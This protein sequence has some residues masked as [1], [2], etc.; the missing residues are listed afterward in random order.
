MRAGLATSFVCAAAALTFAPAAAVAA[1]AEC[2]VPKRFCTDPALVRLGA[3]LF[4]KELIVAGTSARPATWRVRYD[5]LR[6]ELEHG[7]NLDGKPYDATEAGEML[8]EAIA[9]LD[10]EIARARSITAPADA[11]AAL[12]DKCLATWFVH[13]CSVPASGVLRGRDGLTILWQLEEGASEEDGVGMGVLLWDA[14]TPGAPKLI[15]WTFEGAYM[16][17]PVY[18][19][20]AG[21]LWVPG[22]MAGTG[23][24]NADVL[25]QRD[26][27]GKWRQIE[28][29]S[30][31]ADLAKRLPKGFGAWKGIDYDFMGL[32]GTTELWRDSD[33]NCCAT[34][35]RAYLS[36]DIK[37]DSLKLDGIQ[38]DIATGWKP[39]TS[40]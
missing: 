26:D 40:Y 13:G 28:T 7:T 22:T 12:G 8:R 38:A 21:L 25:Y 31:R 2:L 9:D 24:G 18:N 17:A 16:R 35:G 33:A 11:A 29:Q 30:W 15:G 27:D 5:Q 10:A 34:G 19:P 3:D 14:S 39:S 32:G 4:A 37:G 23:E 1:P 20:K 6:D 36:F